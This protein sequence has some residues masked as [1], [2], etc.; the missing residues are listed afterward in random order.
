M[1]RRSAHRWAQLWRCENLR[2][3]GPELK[4]GKDHKLAEYIED[5]IADDKYSPE[6]V[7]G[8]IEAKGLDFNTSISVNTL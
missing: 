4:I 2:A 3:K 7:L 6:A 5:K 1:W 8:E